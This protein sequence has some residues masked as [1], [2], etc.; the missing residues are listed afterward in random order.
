MGIIFRKHFSVSM[1][2]RLFFAFTFSSIRFGVSHL[3]LISLIHSELSLLQINMNPSIFFY[4]QPSCV[5][6]CLLYQQSGVHRCMIYVRV[7]N[8]IPLINVSIFMP[9]PC[10][11]FFFNC[12]CKFQVE[13]LVFMHPETVLLFRMF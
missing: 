7:F 10:P 2:P 11:F 13:R 9:I 5:D 3:I 1:S 4:M 12:T 8:S 6:V